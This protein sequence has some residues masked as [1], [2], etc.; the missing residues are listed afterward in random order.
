MGVINGKQRMWA[1]VIRERELSDM[2]GHNMATHPVP[3][4]PSHTGRQQ[5]DTENKCLLYT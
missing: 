4:T 5:F 1:T 3:D 2:D